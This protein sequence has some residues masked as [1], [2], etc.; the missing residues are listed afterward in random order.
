MEKVLQKIKSVKSG[1]QIFLFLL[2]EALFFLNAMFHQNMVTMALGRFLF[3]KLPYLFEEYS[4]I[5]FSARYYDRDTHIEEEVV[6][7]I[8]VSSVSFFL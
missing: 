1:L 8:L 2:N 5:V 6:I 7:F 4:G 3:C